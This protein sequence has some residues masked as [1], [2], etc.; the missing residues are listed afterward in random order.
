MTFLPAPLLQFARSYIR[1]VEGL[2]VFMLCIDHRGRW[3]D[4]MGAARH[5]TI[6]ESRARRAFDQLARANLLDIRIS[7]AVRYRFAP[8]SEELCQQAVAFAEAYRSNPAGI[9]KMIAS[10]SLSDSVRDFS[11]AFRIKRDDSR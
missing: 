3:W 6:T 5:L 11:D 7:D 4:A 9:V 1:S 10:S 8:G 2:E